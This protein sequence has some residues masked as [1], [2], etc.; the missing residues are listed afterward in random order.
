[1]R[2]IDLGRLDKG[3]TREVL[4]E[5][6]D[7]PSIE[8]KDLFERFIPAADRARRLGD[9][10]RPADILS[11]T[12]DP[13]RGASL[14]LAGST[15]CATCHRVGGKGG[16]GGVGL[17]PDLDA[18]GA[19]YDRAT[20]LRQI[21]EP[22]LVIDPKYVPQALETRA[23]LMHSGL[24]VERSALEVVL[25]DSKHETIR[26]PLAEVESLTPQAKSLMP[27]ALLRDLTA[28]EAADLLDY[29]GSLKA[30]GP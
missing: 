7:S 18:I 4:A 12:G 26:V 24:L 15:L 29:L 13:R 2:S 17:G 30:A 20:L 16:V 3:V 1:M 22:S 8:V 23:G 6:R 14:F 10:V 9:T 25:T 11:L 5:V 28:Q 27:D 19:K 21:L